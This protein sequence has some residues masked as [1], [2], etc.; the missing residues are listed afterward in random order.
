MFLLKAEG[1]VGG[2]AIIVGVYAIQG[3]EAGMT[4]MPIGE[5]GAAPTLEMFPGGGWFVLLRRT[6]RC[7][8]CRKGENQGPG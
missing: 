5:I 2:K 7:R 3:G 8:S 1:I 4:A 6:I